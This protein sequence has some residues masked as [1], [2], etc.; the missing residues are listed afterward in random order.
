M[1]KTVG[2]AIAAATL[3]VAVMAAPIG[4]AAAPSTSAAATTG[5]YIVVL[6]DNAA[7][8]AVASEHARAY[9]ATVTHVYQSAL[10]GYSARMSAT[11]AARL[12]SDPR[13]AWVEADAPVF[14]A[15]QTTPSGVNRVDADLSPTADIDG[16]DER[17]NVDVAVIDSGIDLDHP[18]LNVYTAGGYDCTGS[19]TADDTHGHGSH[20]AGVIG[21]L[22]NTIGYVGVAPGARLWPVRVLNGS[23]AGTTATLICGIDYVTAHASEIEVANVSIETPGSDDNNCGNTN[24]DTL[25]MAICSSVAAGVT[26]VVAA[27]NSHIDAANVRPASYNEVITVSGLADFNGVP[28]GGGAATC[29]STDV[30]DTFLNTSN[31]GADIDVMAPGLCIKSVYPGGLYSQMSGT[32]ASAPH[33]AGGAALYKATHP[34]ATPAAV[35]TALQTWGNT[36]WTFPSEDLDG[37]QEKLLNVSTF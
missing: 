10:H 28:G 13:V 30:D 16:V 2:A 3:S 21:E 32:S 24:N 31:Y 29:T 37:V 25:H 15:A 33:V 35:K 6:K 36:G 19:G 1:R 14:A 34:T 4:A 8:S 5:Q 22:D 23:G 27:G 18:D 17:V 26:Y 11:A 12:K 9:G 20:V 7:S